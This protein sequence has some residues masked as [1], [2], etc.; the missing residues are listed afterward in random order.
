MR[1]ESSRCGVSEIH[2]FHLLV[3]VLQDARRRTLVELRVGNLAWEGKIRGR[4]YALHE[5]LAYIAQELLARMQVLSAPANAFAAK[6][7]EA[8][9]EVFAACAWETVRGCQALREG[10][11]GSSVTLVFKYCAQSIEYNAKV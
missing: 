9:A 4:T 10:L 5:G 6:V 7:R 2:A 1:V 11:Q 3:V 8:A